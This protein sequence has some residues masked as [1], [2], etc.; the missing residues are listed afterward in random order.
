VASAPATGD[1]TCDPTPRTVTT[2]DPSVLDQLDAPL[3]VDVGM[4][5]NGSGYLAWARIDITRSESGVERV[6]AFDLYG[7]NC[8]VAN[9]CNAGYDYYGN[10]TFTASL[11][12]LD[13]DGFAD[14]NDPDQDGDGFADVADNCPR[15]ANPDQ[16]D[17]NGDG[18][19]LACQDPD[20]DGIESADDNCPQDA[21][22]DQLDPN[23][24]GLGLACQDPDG[25]GIESADDN[26]PDVGNPD[27][28]DANGDGVGTACQDA[29][30]DGIEGADDNCSA[31]SNPDQ[32]DADNNG[33]GNACDPAFRTVVS[34]PW[35]GDRAKAHE[36]YSGGS[37]VLQAVAFVPNDGDGIS[38]QSGTWDAGDGSGPQAINVGNSL[39]LE[40]THTYTGAV[41]QPFTATIR[42][43]DDQGTVY[44][45]TMKVVIRPDTR[46]TRVNM[47]ID[48]GLWNLH[49]R[50]Q[51]TTSDNLPSSYW[52]GPGGWDFT[53]AASTVQAFQVNGHRASKD[54]TR[55]PYAVNVAR[56][57]R[58]ILSSSHGRLARIPVPLQNGNDPDANGNGDG[59]I[60]SQYD[61]ASYVGG[62]LM[63]ALVASGTPNKVADTGDA[64]HVRGRTY[65]TIVQDLLDGYSYGFSDN[66]GGWYYGYSDTHGENDTSASHWWAIG[67]LASEVLGLDAPQWVKTIQWEIGVPLMQPLNPPA[68]CQFGYTNSHNPLW[69]DGTNTTAAGL[70]LLNAD[71][72]PKSHPRYTC[73]MAYLDARFNASMGNFYTM[74]QTVK[75]MRTA[76]DAGGNAAAITLLNGTTDWYAAY[77]DHLVAN[78]TANGTGAFTST[79]GTTAGIIS[80]D[81][82]TSWAIIMLSTSL[83]EQPPTAVCEADSIV[84]SAGATC[85]AAQVGTYATANFDGGRSTRGDNP[86]AGYSWTFADGDSANGVH[87]THAFDA[88]GTCNVQLTVTDTKGNASSA[89]CPVVVTDTALPPLAD[90]GG[91]HDL[92]KG[93][94]E[95]LILDASDSVGRGSNIVEYVWDWTAPVDFA[96]FNAAGATTGD[97]AAAFAAVSPGTYD[98]GVRVTDDSN[99]AFTVIDYSTIT[100]R[101]ANDPLCDQC[102]NDPAKREPGV[103]GCGVA[104][105]T[106]D[107]DG[108]GTLDCFDLCPDDPA[109]VEPGVCDCGTSDVDNDSDGTAS[110]I[111]G[112]PA[113][114]AKVAAG[115]CGCGVADVDGDLDG[116]LDC[117]DACPA[118]ANKV[119]VGQC[120][121]GA[122]DTDTDNDHLA[123]CVDGCPADG[124]KGEAGQCGCGAP[125]TDTDTDGTA[126]CVDACA[127]DADKTDPGI[128]GCGV[129]DTDTDLD[130]VSDCDDNCDLDANAEQF[131]AD[132]D[133]FGDACDTDDDDDGVGDDTDNCDLV[134][135]A[136]QADNDVDG[137]GDACDDDDDNDGVIDNADNCVFTAN[138]DQADNDIDGQGDACDTDDDNDGVADLD[139]NCAFVANADQL[140]S[141]VDPSGDACD[142]DD[143]G[144]AVGDDDD[145]CPVNPNGEQTDT[146]H[147]GQGDACDGDDDADSLADLDDNCP[148]VANLEQLDLDNDNLGD[149]CDADDDGDN[150][151]D[152]IDNCPIVSNGDQADTDGDDA[153]DAC[154]ADDDNDGVDDGDDN[155]ALIANASQDNNDGDVAGD[156][157]DNDDD[158]DG[159]DDAADNCATVGNTDQANLD[160]DLEGDACD[161]DDD[162][163]GVEDGD[164]NCATVANAGQDDLDG[165]DAG[166]VCDPDDDNDGVNDGGDNCPFVANPG[167]EN[168]D[169]DGEGGDA[170]DADDDND[171]VDDGDDNCAALENADQTDLDGDT[172]GDAC[173]G[174]LDGDGVGNDIDNCLVTP[175]GDQANLDGDDDGDACDSDLDGDGVDN[176]PDNC[177]RI[178]NA[179][180][181]DNDQDSLGD[182]CDEDDDNDTVADAQDN[183]PN[184]ANGGQLDSDL[185]GQGDAC[186]GD[187]DND[188][189]ADGNDNCV[190]TAN[191]DQVDTDADGAGNAC[192]SDDDGDAVADGDDN[193]PLVSNEN[194]R[195]TDAD[196]QGDACDNDD[197]DDGV[198]DGNDL[199]ESTPPDVVR[200]ASGC[201]IDQ[202]CP[203]AGPYGSNGLWSSHG[204]YVACVTHASKEFE[205][206]R[207]ISSR[208]RSRIVSDAAR[209]SCGKDPCRD[210]ELRNKN[211][212]ND[213]I[214]F[215]VKVQSF[216]HWG[217]GAPNRARVFAGMTEVFAN[218][219]GE[220]IV[221]LRSANGRVIR[222]GVD[223]NRLR[224][225]GIRNGAYVVLRRG[226]GEIVHGLMGLFGRNDKVAMEV[227]TTV[228]GNGARRGS[229]RNLNF[230][231]QGNGRYV[232]GQAGED[233]FFVEQTGVRMGT[234]V[235]GHVDLVQTQVCDGNPPHGWDCDD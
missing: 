73:A 113:D 138:H 87:A 148:L 190:V 92:C 57:L 131:D 98:V 11:P 4:Y 198:P 102:P 175:N 172:V 31:R 208:D 5:V 234:T 163:D 82:S 125:D 64:T 141:D 189:V 134:D 23:G 192:D 85:G 66:T 1:C 74:Y 194:Q 39:V 139:D 213:G 112:C 114:A 21:N 122:P 75:A 44:T 33:V 34:V 235:T 68:G 89:I 24:D 128:C 103:C 47:A 70:I 196:G 170:C 152:S 118:D 96:L 195:D 63:D 178:A 181:S 223:P 119:A 177:D 218:G 124:D 42:V 46:E 10:N 115:V 116:T 185:D 50:T 129:S 30:A 6:C 67:V 2:T 227:T 219:Q 32:G 187:D 232:L 3:C 38:L 45:D 155:C 13:S 40:R 159:V 86:I 71:D 94:G 182:A 140:N 9:L 215:V 221:P 52:T 100:I 201:T 123:D 200:D 97:V 90:A 179:V 214:A 210:N 14:C 35:G 217:V 62:P 18:L 143:D 126:D 22:P 61:H 28:F 211:N 26:C 7:G 233:E 162:G 209:S 69:D 146:D 79:N 25:D 197:D 191:A 169:N 27:Q 49:G 164:D 133:G 55:N 91:P 166:D 16:L 20:G 212:A 158:N 150:V 84:C 77:A 207:L 36:V 65:R 59:L 226:E 142:T 78:Q 136:D 220:Y 80:G 165:D 83:F 225:S 206:R 109:K 121:C 120:G 132:L 12:D 101:A 183:C 193:C 56:G 93:Q 224:T 99:P 145:N 202:L 19:G 222:D 110:C 111:D 130:G 51:R 174:D 8:D 29:D 127:D 161:A 149:L 188:T 230:E 17:P 135:N 160:L 199:C 144:D 37:L 88:V 106:G 186:D 137:F 231:R 167:Q 72:I 107:A 171:G 168:N 95:S 48:R 216:Q 228:R 203:C 205:R 151:D 43:V 15:V 60:V 156:P 154:D 76:Q 117:N 41:N 229:E 108:D 54:A 147:D 58:F 157:C 176:G 81:M 173:D 180:Q 53:V 184:T 204:K 104:E 153:G 105:E